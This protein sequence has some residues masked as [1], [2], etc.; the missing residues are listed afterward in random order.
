MARTSVNMYAV[1][2]PDI[3]T[4]ANRERLPSSPLTWWADCRL[5][6]GLFCCCNPQGVSVSHWNLW[7]VLCHPP[8]AA[9]V[10]ECVYVSI[11]PMETES[12]YFT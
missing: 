9:C 6:A 10:V 2:V 11:V 5:L 3:I 7:V 4:Y 1:C 12:A 8:C